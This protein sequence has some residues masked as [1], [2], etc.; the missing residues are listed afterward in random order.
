MIF[1]GGMSLLFLGFM[2]LITDGLKVEE[3]GLFLLT[4]TKGILT[5]ICAKLVILEILS[6]NFDLSN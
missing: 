1:L 2:G 4:K 6:L 5:K 3:E